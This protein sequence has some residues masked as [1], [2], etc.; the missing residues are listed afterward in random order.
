MK[1]KTFTALILVSTFIII[2][3][4]QCYKDPINDV[5]AEFAFKENTVITPYQV[6]YRVGDTL[7]LDLNI[8]NKR[9]LDTISGS[10]VFY[11]SVNFNCIVRVDLLYNNPFVVND[12]LADFIFPLGVSA[13]TY[14]G[15]P[16]THSQISFGCAP[17]SNYQL[18]IGIILKEKGVLGISF[19]NAYLKKCFSSSFDPNTLTL[20]FNVNDPHKNLYL[21]Q[22]MSSIGK[23]HDP[24]FLN[25]LDARTMV[26]INVQ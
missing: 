26:A 25:M 17:S 14:T 4:F 6:N 5:K 2:A 24:V 3:G 9:I 21:Q 7:W 8:P 1:E 22:P 10:R 13:Y 11:D 16:Q 12:P 23:T 15:G 19:Y 18:S 20:S